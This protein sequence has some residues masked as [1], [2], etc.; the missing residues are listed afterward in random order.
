MSII[1]PYREGMISLDSIAIT[2]DREG[3]EA[4]DMRAIDTVLD[5]AATADASPVLAEVFA[6]GAE[7]APVRERAFGL[8]AMQITSA[9]AGSTTAHRLR[10]RNADSMES[11]PCSTSNARSRR[12]RVRVPASG[13]ELRA[14]WRI[15]VP[16]LR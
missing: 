8:L 15:R 5:L 14:S 4:L 16:T 9:A 2:I 12:S 11:T 6:D 13:A 7:P 3:F 1:Q 10:P